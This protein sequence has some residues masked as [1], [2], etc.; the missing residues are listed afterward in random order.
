MYKYFGIALLG[1]FATMLIPLSAESSTGSTF[2]GIA[3]VTT[4]DSTGNP[5]STQTVHNDLVDLGEE[6]IINQVFQ[7]ATAPLGAAETIAS[8]CVSEDATFAGTSGPITSGENVETVADFDTSDGLTGVDNCM[9]DTTVAQSGTN[10]V[11]I[12]TIDSGDTFDAGV[13]IETDSTITVIGICPGHAT[14]TEWETCAI[15]GDGT[16][17]VLFALVDIIDFTLAANESATITYVF[18]VDEE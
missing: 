16:N 10:S 5:T 6:F 1:I 17:T 7:T 8:I 15:A 11:G 4:F 18:D 2:Y 3:H 13:N 12:A 14:L 9:E